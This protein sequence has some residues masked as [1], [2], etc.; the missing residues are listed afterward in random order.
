MIT[1]SK[2]IPTHL[3]KPLKIRAEAAVQQEFL[4]KGGYLTEV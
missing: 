4:E 2:S 3:I 1:D